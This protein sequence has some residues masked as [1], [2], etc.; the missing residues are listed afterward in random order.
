MYDNMKTAVVRRDE[1]GQP[2]WN[3]GLLD[4]ARLT[5]FTPTV[6]WPYRTQTKGKVERSIRYI[7]TMPLSGPIS[8]EPTSLAD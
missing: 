2:E 7:K 5:G 8:T 1:N 6:C 3:Q 4:F